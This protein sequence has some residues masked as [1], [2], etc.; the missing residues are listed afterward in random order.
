MCSSDLPGPLPE[1]KSKTVRVPLKIGIPMDAVT[2][3]E[4][5]GKYYAELELR[6]AALGEQGE[7]NE[8][9]VIPV[10]LTGDRPP[11]HGEHSIYSTEVAL[12]RQKQE[13]VIALYDPASGKLLEA[14]ATMNP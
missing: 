12:T 14:K 10:K 9:K 3:I 8:V 2:M 6:V 11:K 4:R 7:R 5:R 13:I 1:G